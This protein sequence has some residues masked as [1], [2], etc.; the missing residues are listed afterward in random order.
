MDGVDGMD[1]MDDMDSIM[2][3][4]VCHA[5]AVNSVHPVHLFRPVPS[6]LAFDA[7]WCYYASC[8]G[9]RPPEGGCP[10]YICA[11]RGT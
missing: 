2:V 4:A 11:V 1:G 10:A 7:Q 9:G 8:T 5:H 3:H 6:A